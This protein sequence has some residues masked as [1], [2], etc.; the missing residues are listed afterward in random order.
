MAKGCRLR[1]ISNGEVDK[2]K[3]SDRKRRGVGMTTS[4]FC[5]VPLRHGLP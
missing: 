1:R 3:G 4:L 5:G 2:A